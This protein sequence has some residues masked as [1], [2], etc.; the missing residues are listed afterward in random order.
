MESSSKERKMGIME[1][2][3]R[4]RILQG[5]V[6]NGVTRIYACPLILF[7][8]NST[9]IYYAVRPNSSTSSF[10]T[11]SSII[12]DKTSSQNHKTQLDAD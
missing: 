5:S 9:Q 12:R 7:I 1:W 10:S 4:Q 6:E 11:P 8:N 2:R 3:R